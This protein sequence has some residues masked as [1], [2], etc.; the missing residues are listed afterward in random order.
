MNGLVMESLRIMGLG[1]AGI[2]VVVAVFYFT[3]I[4][5]NKIFPHKE[6]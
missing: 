2:F 3:I 5:L 1:M 6:Q 4:A